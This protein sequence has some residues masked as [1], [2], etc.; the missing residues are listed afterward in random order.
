MNQN[1]ELSHLIMRVIGW[2]LVVTAGVLTVAG[3]VGTYTL[4]DVGLFG[5][6]FAIGFLTLGIGFL[7]ASHQP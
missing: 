7:A 2:F 4:G 1:A 5:V 6:I 3:I